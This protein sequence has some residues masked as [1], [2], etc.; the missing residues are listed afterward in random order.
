MLVTLWLD[1]SGHTLIKVP[2]A[3][4]IWLKPSLLEASKETACPETPTH[5][6]HAQELPPNVQFLR[7]SLAPGRR[8]ME[9]KLSSA[10]LGRTHCLQA[11][12]CHTT[13][14]RH[15]LH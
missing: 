11:A 8:P 3:S 4:S 15:L 2:P 6:E 1:N 5:G 9:S 7:T 13:Y 10:V 14:N 12:Y